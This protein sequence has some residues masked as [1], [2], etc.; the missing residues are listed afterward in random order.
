[1]KRKIVA[2]LGA[3]VSIQFL[4]TNFQRPPAALWSE[5]YRGKNTTAAW[6]DFTGVIVNDADSAIFHRSVK[7]RFAERS[8][9]R[10]YPVVKILH[11]KEVWTLCTHFCALFL[12]CFDS[13]HVS[14]HAL[15]AFVA[16]AASRSN[17]G[18]ARAIKR[19]STYKRPAVK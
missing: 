2:A 6:P 17:S 18:I 1:M 5:Q 13:S 9:N 8:W 19:G 7:E 16:I 10:F 3:L 11:H 4:V 14:I 12:F 15:G